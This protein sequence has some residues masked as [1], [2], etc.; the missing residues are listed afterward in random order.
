MEYEHMS[1][2]FPRKLCR[3]GLYLF[4]FSIPLSFV[5]AEFAIAIVFI[6]WL[7]EGILN[8]HWQYYPTKLYIP[9]LFYIAWNILASGCSPRPLH[10]LWALADNEWPMF[11]MLFMISLIDDI[12]TLRRMTHLW[13]STA[14]I[15]AI[16]GVWQM[17][18]GVELIHRATLG[19]M[20]N[21]FRA[22]G[23]N[24]FYLTFAGFMMTVF[25]VALCLSSQN[26]INFR[27]RYYI[28]SIM[29]FFAIVG[30]F[31]R[32]VWLSFLVVIPIFSFMKGKKLGAFVI[33]VFLCL[34]ILCLV[35]VPAIRDRA[36]S[37]VVPSENQTR[38][39]LWKTSLHISKDYP[40]IGIGED[41]F[42]Y[43]F[44]RYRVEG[45]YDAIG[46]PHND[47]LTVLISSGIPGLLAFL[48][49]WII[50]IR[51]GLKTA[52]LS[53]DTFLREL[54]L[55]GTLSILGFLVGG[56]FQNY[57]GTFAN[58]WGWWFMAG[59]TMTSHRLAKIKDIKS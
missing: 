13:L 37:I 41:N 22:V 8:K 18:S 50:I 46:H 48:S 7:L 59:L 29:S 26:E 34:M 2:S 56:L 23:F 36:F 45:Y 47:Y 27:W 39:N 3:F 24:G 20:G 5:P 19:P 40:V 35:F 12:K 4:A 30:T 42:D 57:Y 28:V 54:S 15:A 16:Y 52:R 17:F 25:L 11:I 49:M 53:T 55:G 1:T 9:L 33:V 38:L 6:G 44:N 58:C 10:S 43:Y 51:I 31:A 32:S 14:L 21:Y